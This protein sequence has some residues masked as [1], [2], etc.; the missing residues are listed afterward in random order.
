MIENYRELEKFLEDNSEKL[1]DNTPKFTIG[2][3]MPENGRATVHI[4]ENGNPLTVVNCFSWHETHII[5]TAF[6]YGDNHRMRT[7]NWLSLVRS[8]RD[9]MHYYERVMVRVA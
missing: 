9:T 3:G 7:L 6:V 5:R 8:L 2:F 4:L 1:M